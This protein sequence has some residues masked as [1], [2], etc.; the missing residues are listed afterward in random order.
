MAN[1]LE[2]G[3]LRPNASKKFGIGLDVADDSQEVAYRR[4]GHK[5]QNRHAVECC[6]AKWVRSIAE[7]ERRTEWFLDR[8]T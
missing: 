8:R 7:R 4:A 3:A 6:S 2:P 5:Q 1:L